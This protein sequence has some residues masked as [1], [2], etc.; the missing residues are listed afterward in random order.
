MIQSLPRLMSWIRR[1]ER[2]Q[3]G[4]SSRLD[5]S[6]RRLRWSLLLRSRSRRSR[7]SR[8]RFRFQSLRLSLLLHL[9]HS[10]RQ[11]QTQCL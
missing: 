3:Q 9:L 4:T 5:S 2:I 11:T 7:R 10:L 6:Y 8:F 1:W